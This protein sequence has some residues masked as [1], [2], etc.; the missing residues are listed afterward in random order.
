MEVDVGEKQKA[1]KRLLVRFPFT[2]AGLLILSFYGITVALPESS[3]RTA[4]L[5]IARV[6]IVPSYLVWLAIAVLTKALHL[7]SL[8]ATLGVAVV[9]LL[10]LLPY[11]AADWIWSRRSFARRP[12]A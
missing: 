6:L 7:S 12:D 10:G 4:L 2:I 3:T 11:V 8:G 1:M 9:S 5:A